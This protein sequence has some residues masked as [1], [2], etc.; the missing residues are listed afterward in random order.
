MLT[1]VA[2][3]PLLKESPTKIVSRSWPRD[4]MAETLVRAATTPTTAGSVPT[5]GK[6]AFLSGLAPQSAAVRLFALCQRVD[7]AGI[8]ELHVPA[9]TTSPVPVFIGEGLPAPMKEAVIAPTIIGPVRKMLVGTG[10]TSELEFAVPET[11]SVIIGRLLS[12]QAGKSL[13][14]VLFDNVAADTTRPAGLLN[15]VTP[16]TATAGGGLVA[17]ATDLANIADAIATAGGNT[18]TIA[19]VANPRQAIVLRLL[20]SPSFG[21][22]V[23]GCAALADGTIIGVAPD[24]VM[25]GYDGAPEIDVSKVAT[26]QFENTTPL[27]IVDGSSTPAPGTR[28]AWQTDT[29]FLRLRVKCCWGPLATG[30][31]QVVNSTSW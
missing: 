21:Y 2:L 30:M 9:A 29:L 5:G 12:E 27:P 28:S 22:T 4:A 3:G 15:G 11:A 14:A 17:I 10:I 8:Y 1:A 31:V 18:D 23:I 19:F 13:D 7:M 16:I 6:F 20:A 25:S 26:A 24:A